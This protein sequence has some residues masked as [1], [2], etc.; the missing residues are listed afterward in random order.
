MN[1]NN[2]ISICIM[3][4][5]LAVIIALATYYFEGCMIR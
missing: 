2:V 1:W 5:V 3:L 4:F